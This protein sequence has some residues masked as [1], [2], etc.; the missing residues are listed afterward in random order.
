[1]TP[2]DE[3][4]LYAVDGARCVNIFCSE[5]LEVPDWV[6]RYDDLPALLKDWGACS[7]D[8]A[9]MYYGEDVIDG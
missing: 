3:E 4:A 6:E 9:Y 8:C 1:M 5:R 2:E 7:W